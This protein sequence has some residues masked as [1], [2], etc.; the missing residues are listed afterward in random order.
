MVIKI[1]MQ[2]NGC[3]CIPKTV[4]TLMGIDDL[5]ETTIA[6]IVKE[7]KNGVIIK[8]EKLQEKGE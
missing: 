6:L 2:K 3:I 5:T 7:G 8:I 4:R 1:K